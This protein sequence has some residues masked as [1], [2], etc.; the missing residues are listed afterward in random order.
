MVLALVECT[1]FDVSASA[2]QVHS[3]EVHS[4]EVLATSVVAARLLVARVACICL[5]RGVGA[6]TVGNGP[7]VRGQREVSG[8]R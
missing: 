4:G 8:S 1:A 3:G 7:L 2:A 5:V 6:R